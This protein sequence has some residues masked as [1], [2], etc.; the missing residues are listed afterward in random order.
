MRTI[1]VTNNFNKRDIIGVLQLSDDLQLYQGAYLA[2]G[3]VIEKNSGEPA[4]ITL[5][6]VA[7]CYEPAVPSNVFD[8]ATEWNTHLTDRILGRDTT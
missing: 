7:L 3:Y 4:R 8:P 6:E 5:Y 1:P 2:L